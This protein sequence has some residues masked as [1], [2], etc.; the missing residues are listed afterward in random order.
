MKKIAKKCCVERSLVLQSDAKTTGNRMKRRSS[1][2]QTTIHDDDGDN[3]QPKQH[4]EQNLK[5][6]DY[7]K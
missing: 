3:N 2:K 6:N 5:I 4:L 1:K 7:I